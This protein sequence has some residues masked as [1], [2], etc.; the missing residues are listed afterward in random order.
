MSMAE[1]NIDKINIEQT[2]TSCTTSVPSQKNA[3]V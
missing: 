1:D 2:P 3:K